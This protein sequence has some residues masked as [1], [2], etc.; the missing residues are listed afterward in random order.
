MKVSAIRDGDGKGRHTTSYL[1]LHT[2]SQ[3][4][5]EKMMQIA[6]FTREFQKNR[7]RDWNL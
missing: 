2:E 1:Q 6:K 7:Y 3:W 5:K 4:G